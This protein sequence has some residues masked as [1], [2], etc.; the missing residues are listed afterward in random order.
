MHC[1]FL[2]LLTNLIAARASWR[3]L[4][5]PTAQNINVS[6]A[7]PRALDLPE[8]IVVAVSGGCCG[9]GARQP[10]GR[11]SM[12][13][14]RARS[15]LALDPG[16]DGGQCSR[17][18]ARAA[19]YIGA[20][21]AA[22]AIMAARASLRRGDPARPQALVAEVTLTRPRHIRVL[23]R[24]STCPSWSVSVSSALG[25]WIFDPCTPRFSFSSRWP[26]P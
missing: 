7:S 26:S 19:G 5:L 12:R 9:D 10:W 8:W 22:G 3:S 13:R 4:C 6:I 15:L 2:P 21:A 20:F 25:W 14:R 11:R 24:K 23:R 16:A 18:W 1:A 17:R